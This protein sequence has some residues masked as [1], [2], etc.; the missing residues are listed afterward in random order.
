MLPNRM[1]VAFDEDFDFFNFRLVV[2]GA[3]LLLRLL[4]LSICWGAKSPRELLKSFDLS[5]CSCVHQT[6][7]KADQSG[8][9][10]EF[11]LGSGARKSQA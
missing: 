10:E 1:F 9:A 4:R 5:S 8:V 11:Y 7:D 6:V 2:V 3:P